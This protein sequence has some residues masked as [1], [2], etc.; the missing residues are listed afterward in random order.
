M[1][2]TITLWMLS[3]AMKSISLNTKYFVT[4]NNRFVSDG[5]ETYHRISKT[6]AKKGFE[7]GANVYVMSIDRDPISSLTKPHKYR[8]GCKPLCYNNGKVDITSF[9]EVLGD[10]SDWLYNIGYGRIP[11]RYDAENFR[12]SFWLK[13]C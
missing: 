12:F 5:N 7:K 1:Q 13:I 3:H 11:Q 6:I 2:T 8:I 10:F 4:M 9:N